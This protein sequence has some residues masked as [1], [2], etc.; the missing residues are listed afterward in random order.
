MQRNPYIKVS[1]YVKGL[2]AAAVQNM[3]AR[4]NFAKN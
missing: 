4:K 3:A 1:L 2:G